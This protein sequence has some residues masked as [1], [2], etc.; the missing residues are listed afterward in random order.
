MRCK[1]CS[2]DLDVDPVDGF[3]ICTHCGLVA[4]EG[5]AWLQHQELGDA[6]DENERFANVDRGGNAKGD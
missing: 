6:A 2:E 1:K 4:D 3:L 5:S